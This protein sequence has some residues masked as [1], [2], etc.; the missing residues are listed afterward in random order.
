MEQIERRHCDLSRD[1][2]LPISSE[3]EHHFTELRKMASGIHLIG[4]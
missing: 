4:E 1:L 3:L 2:G